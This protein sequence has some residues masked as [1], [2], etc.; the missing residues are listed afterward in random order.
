MTAAPTLERILQPVEVSEEK[1]LFEA[2]PIGVIELSGGTGACAR[3]SFAVS[4]VIRAQERGEPVAWVQ[5]ETG[6]LFPPDLSEAG[7]DLASLVIVQVP[8]IHQGASPV[9]SGP[10]PRAR[11]RSEQQRAHA[12]ELARATE[13][14]LRSGAF[15]LVVVDMTKGLPSGDAWLGRLASLARTHGSRVALI[16][17]SDASSASAGPLVSLRVEPRREHR[18]HGRYSIRAAILKDKRGL[19]E[20]LGVKSARPRAP[21]FAACAARGPWGLG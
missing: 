11:N 17:S 16:T 14:L 7:V 3:F 19:D 21:S 12:Y 20:K 13:L 1:P 4:L 5:F 10:A 15:G 6:S 2:L 8:K 18:G 9:R